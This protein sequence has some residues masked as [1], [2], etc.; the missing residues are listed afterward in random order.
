MP[1][2]KGLAFLYNK[3]NNFDEGTKYHQIAA[4][5]GDSN[6]MYIIGKRLCTG[7][8]ILINYKSSCD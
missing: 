4:D 7:N 8:G 5:R 1:S 6:S 3:M 2:I